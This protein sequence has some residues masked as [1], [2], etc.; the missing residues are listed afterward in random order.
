MGLLERISRPL[1]VY[2]RTTSPTADGD[3][4]LRTAETAPVTLA[5]YL[6]PTDFG[7]DVVEGQQ[8]NNT[9]RATVRDFPAGLD[10]ESLR[11]AR[12]VWGGR[13]WSIVGKPERFDALPDVR[14]WKIHLVEQVTA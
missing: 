11:N 13:T 7:N 1:V 14:H 4:G 12:A 2:P 6:T 9:A 3:V 10:P 8:P 5:A